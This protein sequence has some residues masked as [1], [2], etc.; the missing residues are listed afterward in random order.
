[1]LPSFEFADI[2]RFSIFNFDD[3]NKPKPCFAGS[4]PYTGKRGGQI[5]T[6]L[7]SFYIT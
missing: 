4:L 1:M 6:R 5:A 7:N 2:I 3:L